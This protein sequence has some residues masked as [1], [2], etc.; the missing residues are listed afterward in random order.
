[1]CLSHVWIVLKKEEEEEQEEEEQGTCVRQVDSERMYS[2]ATGRGRPL[3]RGRVPSVSLGFPWFLLVFVGF[4][5][6]WF[7]T[8][9]L[10]FLGFQSLWFSTSGSLDSSLTVLRRKWHIY[11]SLI[12]I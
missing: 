7:S 3:G 12:H 10:V 6:L 11:L 2:G 4:Q 9:S 5:S 1:M 8:I